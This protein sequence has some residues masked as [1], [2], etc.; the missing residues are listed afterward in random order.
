MR[1]KLKKGD[2]VK[3]LIGKDR[4]KTGKI[5]KVFPGREMVLIPGLNLAKKHV[6]PQGEGKPGGIIDVAKPFLV[7]KLALIC[8][9]CGQPTRVGFKLGKKS[10]RLRI[11]RKCK[12]VI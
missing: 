3:V 10:E 8:P 12:Q 4:G 5:E 7:S 6:K 1:V 2:Q 9:K 11:C